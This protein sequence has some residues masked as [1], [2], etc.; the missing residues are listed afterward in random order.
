MRRVYVELKIKV[1]ID[2]DE[3]VDISEV[4]NEMDYDLCSTTYG[5][6]V[7]DTEII[8]SNITDSK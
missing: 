8:D 7:Y 1:I 4:I 3:G 2:A 6:D 5:A